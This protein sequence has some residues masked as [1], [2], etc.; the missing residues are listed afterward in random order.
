MTATGPPTVYPTLPKDEW[1]MTVWFGRKPSAVKFLVRESSVL[2]RAAY[3][4]R[5]ERN[6]VTESTAPTRS[7]GYIRTG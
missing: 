3:L 5:F 2:I 1:T 4:P 6:R 7:R